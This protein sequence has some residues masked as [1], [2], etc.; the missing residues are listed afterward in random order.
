M[1]ARY[2]PARREIRIVPVPD[3]FAARRRSLGGEPRLLYLLWWMISATQTGLTMPVIRVSQ[4]TWKRLQTHATPLD[5]TA[6]DVVEMALDALEVYVRKGRHTFDA[7]NSAALTKKRASRKRGKRLPLKQFRRPLL[8]AL[9]RHGGKAYSR[10]IRA[11]MER[12]MAPLLS[13]ADHE[14]VSNDL[15]RWWNSTCFMRNQLVEN[16]LFRNDS[17]HGVWE[18]SKQGR[19]MVKRPRS[20]PKLRDAGVSQ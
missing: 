14:L 15:P 7:R 13:D 6:N 18:L 2:E 16:G 12:M 3:I 9:Y 8:E 17:Q 20:R 5:H 4:Q 11:T 10:E 19:T 1:T